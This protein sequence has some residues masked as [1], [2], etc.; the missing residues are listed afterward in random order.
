MEELISK[1]E[2]EIRDNVRDLLATLSHRDQIY[3]ASRRAYQKLNK[4]CKL[5]IYTT[6][7]KIIEREKDALIARQRVVD[8][9][10]EKVNAINIDLDEAEFIQSHISDYPN[11]GELILH[12]QALSILGDIQILDRQNQEISTRSSITE[13]SSPSRTTNANDTNINGTND[14]TSLEDSVNSTVIQ[15]EQTFQNL[16]QIFYL[17]EWNI[18]KVTPDSSPSDILTTLRISVP[19][20][21]R[22][23]TQPLSNIDIN[24]TIEE[25]NNNTT[26]KTE[27]IQDNNDNNNSTIQLEKQS[28]TVSE[29]E[30][31]IYKLCKLSDNVDGRKLLVSVLNQF[32][33]KQVNSL[34]L[35]SIQINIIFLNI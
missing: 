14:N 17:S 5:I 12:S 32:R 3:T 20:P 28:D 24:I 4:E 8:K 29:V 11:Q 30:E 2:K 19:S 31:S 33:S 1:Q 6:L 34:T 18:E 27:N 23:L 15:M 22:S 35:K 13:L 16:S 26:T 7:K 9:L 10:E 21:R 25:N